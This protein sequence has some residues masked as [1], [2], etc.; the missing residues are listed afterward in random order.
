MY[1]AAKRAAAQNFVALVDTIDHTNEHKF[2]NDADL[3]V[4]F[5][6]YFNQGRF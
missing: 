6:L 4:C 2:T 5:W 1:H 3:E